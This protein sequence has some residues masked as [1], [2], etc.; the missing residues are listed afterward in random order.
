[1]GVAD[2]E[3]PDGGSTARRIVLGGQL[4]RLR[5]G[6][7]ISRPDAGYAIRGSESK[8]SRIELGR[9]SFK[10]RDVADLLSLYGID[11]AAERDQFLA[12]VR[13]SNQPGWWQRYGDVLPR[14]FQ[15]YVGLEESATRIQI[16]ETHFV[17]GLL[18][19][20]AYARAVIGRCLPDSDE[21]DVASRAKLRTQR[22]G[23]IVHP[24]APRVWTVVDEAVLHRQV[25]DPDV[26]REQFERLLELTA[27]PN[28]SLQVLPFARP[29]SGAEAEGSF[30][31]LR[32]AEPELPDIVY[33]E[34]LS[35]ALYL[36]KPNEVELYSK[37]VHRLTA[38]AETPDHSRQLLA[39][40]LRELP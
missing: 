40:R 20:E 13:Q 9:V 31:L 36:D 38:Q 26:L 39:D 21:E 7:G 32:F 8:I 16:V 15:D 23:I 35:G 17:P 37:V 11:D 19:T 1:M 28:V 34:Y 22:Q 33:Q 4:R 2:A 12:L 5:E 30:T 6:R 10:E 18:Q 27:L 3:Y 25:A 14:W 24:R 29:G